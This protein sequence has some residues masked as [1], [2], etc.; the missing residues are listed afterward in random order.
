MSEFDYVAE[1]EVTASNMDGRHN[2]G[3][4]EFRAALVA[5]IAAAEH[6]DQFK[7][8]LFRDRARGQAGLKST[9]TL[10]GMLDRKV[11]K[12]DLDLLHGIVGVVTESGELA[13][14][15]LKKIVHDQPFDRTNVREEIGDQLWYLARLVKW[16]GTSFPD[17]MVRNIKKLRGRHGSSGFS[18]V[19]DTN[20][21]LAAERAIL[22]G[23]NLN[24][25]DHFPDDPNCRDV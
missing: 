18:T 16:A 24:S 7:K 11:G 4:T 23:R 5:V 2:V 9:V 14:V 22:E 1:T 20:R 10:D 19:G 15:L 12:E 25:A 3:V 6:M 8:V 17:E 21:N 13:E